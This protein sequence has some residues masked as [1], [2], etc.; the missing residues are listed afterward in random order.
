MD[1]NMESKTNENVVK[2][3]K[4]ETTNSSA[5]QNTEYN[6]E[7]RQVLKSTATDQAQQQAEQA[8]QQISNSAN[9]NVNVCG[10]ISFIFSM[11]GIFMFGLP[12]GIIA[13]ILGIIGIAT[14]KPETQ[15]NRWMAITG[16]AVGAVEIVVM[17]LYISIV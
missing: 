15:S 4:V 9:K 17:G 14:F 8:N 10:L 12:C 16:L 1:E 6:A 13:T 5:E 2:V 11:I 7:V 3:E